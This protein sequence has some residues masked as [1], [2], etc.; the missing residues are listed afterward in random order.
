MAKFTDSEGDQWLVRLTV[1]EYSQIRNQL[2]IDLYKLFTDES[3]MKIFDDPLIWTTAIY[4]CCES[5]CEKRQINE[6]EFF[7]RLYGD[8]LND[9][10]LAFI[11]AVRDFFPKGLQRRAIDVLLKAQAGRENKMSKNEDQ[12]ISQLESQIE[13]LM[14]SDIATLPQEQLASPT[15]ENLP[16]EN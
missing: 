10:V 9:A 13:A 12:I 7:G 5:Q 15:P 3:Q 8:C 6:A 2:E 1:R 16:S 4:Y 14:S 11:E